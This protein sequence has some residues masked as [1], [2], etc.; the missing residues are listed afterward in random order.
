MVSLFWPLAAAKAGFR[1]PT[2]PPVFLSLETAQYC[3]AEIVDPRREK[4]FFDSVTIDKN[5][6]YSQIIDNLNKTAVV[7][8]PI[9]EIAQRLK[10]DQSIDA[11]MLPALDQAQTC[12]LEF[13]QY[14]LDN[15][16]LDFSLQVDTFLKHICR[17]N[18]AGIISRFIIRI[19]FATTWKRTSLRRMTWSE[20]G[21]RNPNQPC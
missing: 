15:N 5:R 3:M 2:Q 10:T 8:F 7:R 1:Q 11:S 6:I 9:E 16:L 20:N 4:G 18:C 17:W 12:A 19:S 14:C 13:R 21:C